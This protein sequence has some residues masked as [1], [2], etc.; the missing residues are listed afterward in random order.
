MAATGALSQCP[1]D[2]SEKIYNPRQFPD[3]LKLHNLQRFG[4]LT[5]GTL[6]YIAIQYQ[7]KINVSVKR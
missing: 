1:I 3:L 4:E 2:I 6:D 5:S 7:W